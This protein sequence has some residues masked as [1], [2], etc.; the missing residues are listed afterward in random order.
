MSLSLYSVVLL[1]FGMPVYKM[2]KDETIKQIIKNR[3]LKLY[4]TVCIRSRLC[5]RAAVL[6]LPRLCV[7]YRGC[8]KC[9]QPLPR[10]RPS[11]DTTPQPQSHHNY[12][13]QQQSPRRNMPNNAINVDHNSFHVH[14]SHHNR[15]CKDMTNPWGLRLHW[16][17]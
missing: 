9:L 14:H 16:R 1:V 8:N 11:I 17:L 12:A 7:L 4:L 10:P 2:C 6:R 3:L 15:V 13:R 5:L